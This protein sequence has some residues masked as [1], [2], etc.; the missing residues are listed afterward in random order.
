MAKQLTAAAVKRY[1]AGRG[2]REIP[3]GG[4]PGLYV[5]IQAGGYRSWAMRFRRPSGKSAK[6]T[7]GPV[8]L[9]PS[10]ASHGA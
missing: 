3:D 6:L 5:V 10:T 7:L 8:D 4:C 2:R 9:S 1:R